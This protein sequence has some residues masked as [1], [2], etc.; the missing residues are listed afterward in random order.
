MRLFVAEAAS[1]DA[2]MAK[3]AFQGLSRVAKA[4]D[5]PVLLKALAGLRATSVREEAEASVGQ[6]LDRAGDP[7]KASAAVRETMAQAQTVEARC[8]LLRLLN[9]CPDAAALAAVRLALGDP[10]AQVKE[11]ARRTLADW[12][13]ASAW[14]A[15]VGVYRQA[16]SEAE[17]V[18][19]LRGLARLLGEQNARPDAQLVGRYRDLLAGARGDDDR[20]LVLGP[21]AGCADPDALLL[22]VDQLGNAGVR[23]EAELAVKKIAEAIKEKHPQA[24]LSALEKLK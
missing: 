1:S 18:V 5:V 21:L 15:L 10:D 22:A 3:L 7:S 20:K 9:E 23:A 12:P 16:G 6:V 13:N 8:S 19:A 17:R 2:A 24:A 11:A 4:D 14:D